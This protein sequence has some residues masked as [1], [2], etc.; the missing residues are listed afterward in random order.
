MLIATTMK[1]EKSCTLSHPM[2]Q[3]LLP[4]LEQELECLGGR[5]GTSVLDPENV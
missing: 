2:L 1:A 3:E 5:V 4:E